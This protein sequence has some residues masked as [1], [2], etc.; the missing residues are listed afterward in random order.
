MRQAL[1]YRGRLCFRHLSTM[2]RFYTYDTRCLSCG[3]SYILSLLLVNS[4]F[5]T[6]TPH[7]VSEGDQLLTTAIP[8][9]CLLSKLLHS[10]HIVK[11]FVRLS[12]VTYCETFRATS[13]IRAEAPHRPCSLSVRSRCRS[14]E[15]LTVLLTTCQPEFSYASG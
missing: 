2:S 9:Y 14:V 13:G 11:R 3:T 4:L 10:V 5:L 15:H 1:Y 12:E 6:V 8:R 7:V